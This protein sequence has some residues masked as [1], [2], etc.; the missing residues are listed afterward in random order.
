[1]DPRFELV[2]APASEPVTL[3]EAK[4]HAKIEHS[5][6]DPRVTGFIKTAR[7][8]VEKATGRVLLEQTWRVSFESWPPIAS[9]D[10]FRRIDLAKRPIMSVESVSVDGVAVDS[11]FYRLDGGELVVS[12]DVDDSEG[13][14]TSAGI[15]VTFKAGYAANHDDLATLK[16]AVL[17][18]VAHLYDARGATSPQGI[19]HQLI[20]EGVQA[21]LL[22]FVVMEI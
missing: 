11:S 22:P 10:R 20:P 9:G 7:Q 1:V 12:P 18:L 14:I 13:E 2:T 8:R 16:N 17:M 5:F 3:E 6:D 4:Q 15:V 19:Y 21:L